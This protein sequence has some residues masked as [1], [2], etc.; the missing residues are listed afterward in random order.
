M[1]DELD[2]GQVDAEFEAGFS[3]LRDV[4]RA[5]ERHGP[6]RELGNDLLQQLKNMIVEIARH[7]GAF[8]TSNLRLST[9]RSEAIAGLEQAQGAIPPGPVRDDVA[10]LLAT[11]GQAHRP[12]V[13]DVRP[14]KV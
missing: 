13:P 4:I 9:D 14:P 10:A 2:L 5:V 11:L 3:R 12:D 1:A 6:S 8:R 7:V